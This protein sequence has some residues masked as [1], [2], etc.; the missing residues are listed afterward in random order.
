MEMFNLTVILGLENSKA[1]L[2][3]INVA[4]SM[5]VV[6]GIAQILPS[7]PISEKITI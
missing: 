7:E 3:K 1:S 4:T 5:G 2:A 6:E